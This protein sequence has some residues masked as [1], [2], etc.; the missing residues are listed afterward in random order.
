MAAKN[1]KQILIVFDGSDWVE[2]SRTMARDIFSQSDFRDRADRDYI[3]VYADFPHSAE[4]KGKVKNAD[5]N[6]KLQEQFGVGATYPAVV[7][8]DKDGQPWGIHEGNIGNGMTEFN[9]TLDNFGRFG[10]RLKELQAAITTSTDAAKKVEALCN[11]IDMVENNKLT[12]FYST[13]IKDW[14]AMLPAGALNQKRPANMAKAN[15]WLLAIYAGGS[16]PQ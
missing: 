15:E 6:K 14:T 13:Q 3:L 4:A 2:A 11:A 5:R 9:A 8:T 16:A 1:N 7:I 12:R 10:S